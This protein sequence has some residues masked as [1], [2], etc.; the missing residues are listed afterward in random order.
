MKE[1]SV[2]RILEYFNT[3]NF[4]LYLC[5]GLVSSTRECCSSS[6]WSWCTPSP[7]LS[8][9][10]L[11]I[12]LRR[13]C[14]YVQPTDILYLRLLLYTV[15]FEPVAL[16]RILMYNISKRTIILNT[17]RAIIWNSWIPFIIAGTLFFLL[18]HFADRHNL[19]FVYAPSKINKKVNTEFDVK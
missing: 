6:P 3:F 19:A 15:C 17:L 11:V 16:D 10:R 14:K 5:T 2:W 13:P 1:W 9:L 12:V 8:S 4:M 18:K 7:V